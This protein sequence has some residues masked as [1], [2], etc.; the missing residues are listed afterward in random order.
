MEWDASFR[1]RADCSGRA[2]AGV[3]LQAYGDQF[4]GTADAKEGDAKRQK[5]A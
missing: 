2:V 3:H 5:K 4:Q 1:D